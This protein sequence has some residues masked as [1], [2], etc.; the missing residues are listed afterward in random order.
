MRRGRYEHIIAYS[1]PLD[2]EDLADIKGVEDEIYAE[3]APRIEAAIKAE[4]AD[5]VGAYAAIAKAASDHIAHLVKRTTK[6][7]ACKAGCGSCCRSHK[8]LVE[9]IEVIT[10]L[11]T[12]EAASNRNFLRARIARSQPTGSAPRTECAMLSPGDKCMV[13]GVRPITC[14]TYLSKSRSACRDYC[15]GRA[16][17]PDGVFMFPH[18]VSNALYDHGLG[19]IRSAH[20]LP[21]N[22]YELNSILKRIYGDEEVLKAWLDGKPTVEADLVVATITD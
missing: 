17:L 11:R 8:I 6:P 10:I 1:G 15:E 14:M 4:N 2:P 3:M 13:H 22:V 9:E 12:V 21:G 20:G 18:F 16:G 7:P 5:A 19:P